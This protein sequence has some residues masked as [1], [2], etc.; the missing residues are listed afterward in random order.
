MNVILVPGIRNDRHADI[1]Q[2][3][4]GII[5]SFAKFGPITVAGFLCNFFKGSLLIFVPRRQLHCQESEVPL[6]PIRAPILNHIAK[7]GTVL[8]RPTRVGFTLVPYGST[9]CVWKEG[10]DHPVI[11]L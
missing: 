11:K 3:F 6:A 9:D 7:E 1:L 4:G 8:P 10:S 2:R 5:L